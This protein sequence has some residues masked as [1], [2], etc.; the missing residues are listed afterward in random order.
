MLGYAFRLTPPA[1]LIYPK[2]CDDR[3]AEGEIRM[4]FSA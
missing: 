4:K 2:V 1:Q 3:D